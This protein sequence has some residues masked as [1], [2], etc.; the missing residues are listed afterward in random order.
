MPTDCTKINVP[1][2][3]KSSQP[4]P[5]INIQKPIFRYV[6]NRMRE[7]L[8]CFLKLEFCSSPDIVSIAIWGTEYINTDMLF[9][10]PLKLCSIFTNMG[11]K[12]NTAET[13]TVLF[14]C[15]CNLESSRM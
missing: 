8:E 6:K 13:A 14:K 10:M 9:T 5:T 15:K 3:V 4:P 11:D 12:I 7:I 1:H 2:F